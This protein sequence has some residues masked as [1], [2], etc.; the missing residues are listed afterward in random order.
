MADTFAGL[1]DLQQYL[2]RW[3]GGDTAARDHLVHMVGSHLERLT[4]KMLRRF[5]Q[6]QRWA[7]ADDVVQNAMVRL[8][9]A[10]QTVKPNSPRDFFALAA[11]QMRRELIDLARHFRGHVGESA[12]QPERHPDGPSTQNTT[13]DP[14]DRPE[15]PEDLE[16][17]CLFH[18]QVGLLPSAE[19]EVL[20]LV[21][22]H[23]YTQVQVADILQI[24][25][26][27]VRRYYKSA[28]ARLQTTLKDWQLEE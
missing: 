25:E 20:G 28:M 24:S 11:T 9:R 26:R 13:F 5:P 10:L 14:A 18:H 23:G 3:R 16:K 21:Y 6:V 19:R 2:D 22:Y 7:S 17:W 1:T 12:V 4:R 15:N 8:L 27:T